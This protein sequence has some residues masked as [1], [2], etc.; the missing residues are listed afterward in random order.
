MNAGY[1]IARA[2]GY[3]YMA[4]HDVDQIPEI[5]K[6]D[7]AYPEKP[8]HLCVASDQYGYRPAYESMLGGVVALTLEHFSLV[9]GFSNDYWGW[10]QVRFIR[11]IALAAHQHHPRLCSNSLVCFL[12]AASLPYSPSLSFSM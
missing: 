9:N 6:N 12:P 4:L 5:I 11:R 7:Y 1:H 3:D 8:T 10:G 2:W